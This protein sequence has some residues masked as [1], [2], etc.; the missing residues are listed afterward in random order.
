VPAAESQ[1]W[2]LQ[3]A[4]PSSSIGTLLD[5]LFKPL[6]IVLALVV[7]VFVIRRMP[8]GINNSELRSRMPLIRETGF[9]S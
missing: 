8:V 1:L 6:P 5:L 3:E 9:R 4:F 7:A 2:F